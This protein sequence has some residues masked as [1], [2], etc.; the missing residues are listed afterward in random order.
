M[1]KIRHNGVNKN[2]PKYKPKII[3]QNLKSIK[4][5]NE[6]TIVKY[7]KSQ[8]FKSLEKITKKHLI[9]NLQEN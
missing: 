2:E 4:S 6:I 9:W 1:V 5:P 8:M 3:K 7:F